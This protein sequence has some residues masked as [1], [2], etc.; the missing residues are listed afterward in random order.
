MRVYTY[1]PIHINLLFTR[2]APGTQEEEE[3][4]PVVL[5][6]GGPARL[7]PGALPR[8]F[9]LGTPEARGSGGLEA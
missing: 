2:L 3:E 1:V 7:A 9:L 4:A 6:A 5:D 8:S